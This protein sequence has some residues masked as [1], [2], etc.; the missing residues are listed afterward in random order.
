[1]PLIGLRATGQ[2][3]ELGGNATGTM[4]DRVRDSVDIVRLGHVD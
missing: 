3:L 4:A 2:L 1:V